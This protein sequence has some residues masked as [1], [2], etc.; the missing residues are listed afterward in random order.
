[1]PLN[2]A[3]NAAVTIAAKSING[4]TVTSTFSKVLSMNIDYSKGM[5][6][7][8]DADQGSF[9]F[10]M[11]FPTTVTYTILGTTTTVAIS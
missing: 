4:D 3:I 9:F 2:P 7:I 1:M 6:N 8:V 11:L 10:S 5:I